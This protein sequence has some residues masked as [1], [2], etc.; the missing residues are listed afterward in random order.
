MKRLF[1][2]TLL[3]MQAVQVARCEFSTLLCAVPMVTLEI[4]AMILVPRMFKL[5]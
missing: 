1:P 5:S 2:S 3:A 4:F